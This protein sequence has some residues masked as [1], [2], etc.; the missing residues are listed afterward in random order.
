M[1][2]KVSSKPINFTVP[3]TRQHFP[4]LLPGHMPR[5][6]IS[7]P[8]LRV[9]QEMPPTRTHPSPVSSRTINPI[10]PT[11][12]QHFPYLL[13]GHMPREYISH[14]SLRVMQEMPP[15]LTHPS[16]VSSRTI[17]PIVPTTRQHSPY[18]LPAC[19]DCGCTGHMH[20]SHPSQKI[21][22]EM[23][24]TRTHP[25]PVSS[26][27]INPIIPTTRQHFP[28]LLPGHMLREYISHPSLRVMQEMPP[29]LTHPSPVSSRAINPIVPTTRQ[30][31]PYLL[32]ACKDCGCTGH[33]H[34]SHPSQK[35]KQE[36][37]PTQTHPSP[38]S[39]RTINPIIPTTRQ[40]F[41]YLLPACRD[42]GCTG[43]IKQIS[44]PSPRFMQEMPPTWTHPSP[45]SSG[46]INLHL[47]MQEITP[48][49]IHPPDISASSNGQ[50][51]TPIS[52]D[53]SATSNGQTPTP[54]S[55]PTNIHNGAP[56]SVNSIDQ[57]N[58]RMNHLNAQRNPWNYVHACHIDVFI[59]KAHK[60]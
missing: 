52:T 41:P 21:K 9:M 51:P 32:P 22:Q 39:S 36:M 33:M 60:A 17:N 1:D 56:Q 24:P 29:T 35:I 34:I 28:Y 54:I 5:E 20:I 38:V 40:H 7:H 16:P 15:T 8:S 27:T 19:K 30:H 55:T 6:Y 11:T 13:P 14:P 26:R 58:P 45:I 12:R 18:L 3:M 49:W 53:I 25:S 2:P 48:T 37:P 4:Y 50:I 31:S 42:C 59:R 46:T 57:L 10:I 44:Q 43:H 47:D 23:P